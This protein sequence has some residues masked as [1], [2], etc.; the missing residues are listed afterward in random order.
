MYTK[1]NLDP[2]NLFMPN[3]LNGSLEFDVQ[4][5][6]QDCGCVAAFYQVNMPA[7]DEEGKRLAGKDGTYYCDANKVGGAFCPEF[8]IMEANKYSWR[9]TAH[10]C[11]DAS[12][13]GFFNDCDRKGLAKDADEWGSGEYGPSGSKINTPSFFHLKMDYCKSMFGNWEGYNLELSQGQYCTFAC[14]GNLK[15]TGSYFKKLNK[16]LTDG[17]AFVF[18]NWGSESDDLSWLNHDKCT[19]ACNDKSFFILSN[20]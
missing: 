5:G 2:E 4:L 3:L 1:P 11:E 16:P 17:M 18:S 10:S 8:D 12:G 9:T 6:S 19:G 13:R 20:F 7:L 14:K 15:E